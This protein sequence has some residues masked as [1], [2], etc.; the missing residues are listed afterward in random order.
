MSTSMNPRKASKASKRGWR[1]GEG[2]RL[3]PVTRSKLLPSAGWGATSS[4]PED[5]ED[6]EMR[7]ERR[8]L[9]EG[10]AAA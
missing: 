10:N 7:G 1:D 9:P 8:L 3:K 2:N 5:E 6:E 4:T